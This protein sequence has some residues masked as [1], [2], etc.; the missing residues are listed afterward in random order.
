MLQLHG[1][2]GQDGYDS[3]EA[4]ENTSSKKGTYRSSLEL[5]IEDIG[6]VLEAEGNTFIGKSFSSILDLF[7]ARVKLL[8]PGKIFI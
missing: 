2:L 1:S 8:Y 3:S 6:S 4:S 5:I 7:S